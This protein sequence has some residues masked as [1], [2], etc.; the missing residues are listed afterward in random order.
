MPL[1]QIQSVLAKPPEGLFA[2]LGRIISERF[3]IPFEKVWVVWH[4]VS[5]ELVHRPGLDK[6]IDT[7]PIVVMY[8]RQVYPP[9][10]VSSVLMDIKTS[11]S[12][13][14]GCSENSVFICVQRVNPGELLSF[15]SIWNTEPTTPPSISVHPIGFVRSPVRRPSDDCWG[16]VR[17]TIELDARAFGPDSLK[18]LEAFS[19]VDVVFLCDL[20]EPHDI[21]KGSRHPR[22]RTDWP[23]VGVFAQRVKN[24]PNRIAV[25]TCPLI[26]IDGTH[27]VV[28]ELDAVDGTPVLDIKPYFKEFGPRTPVRQP[29]WSVELMQHYFDADPEQHE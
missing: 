5:P 10:R 21:V 4:P 1:L 12:Q 17:A 28:S 9:W 25:T 29:S 24:R 7:G 26:A 20:V 14:L 23:A 2:S 6:A 18:G 27:V 8:C 19:H 16:D 11:L 22:G 3:G 15:G 13:A